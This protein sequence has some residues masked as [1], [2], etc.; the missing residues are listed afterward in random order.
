[1]Q[2]EKRGV[3]GICGQRGRLE[4][5]PGGRALGS[6]SLTLHHRQ[7]QQHRLP[8]PVLPRRGPSGDISR[9]ELGTEGRRAV[10][11]R[12]TLLWAALGN[13]CELTMFPLKTKN[14]K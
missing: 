5:L 6:D 8:V 4:R 1:M 12:D 2:R 3:R 10:G 9:E 14:K 11:H 7:A 13:I